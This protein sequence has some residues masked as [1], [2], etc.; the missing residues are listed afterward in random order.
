MRFGK[1]VLGV[2]AGLALCVVLGGCGGLSRSQLAAPLD[3]R[4]VSAQVRATAP[5]PPELRLTGAAQPAPEI[6]VVPLPLPPYE[7]RRPA[8]PPMPPAT[9]PTPPPANPIQ[10]P[11]NP[12][13]PPAAN[14]LENI[15]RLQA[16]AAE[17]VGT[18]DSYIVRLTRREVVNGEQKPE[19]I[20]LFKFRNSPWSV[21]FKWLGEQGHGREVVY[22]KGQYE[23][24]LHTRLAA[25]DMP[26]APAGKRMALS[27][28]NVLVR[29]ASR[30]PITEAGLAASV[31]RL[32]RLLAG[33]DRHDPRAGSFTD[34][35]Q[36][37][38][39]EF[40]RP[41]AAIEH[42]IPPGV[43]PELPRGGRR[44]YGFDPD[45]GLPTLIVTRDHTG[46]EVEYYFHDR[47]QFPVH[48]DDSDFNPDLLWA[49]PPRR[50]Q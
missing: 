15:R 30:H 6:P 7:Q 10:P 1:E 13:M 12:M 23:D 50:G 46:R 42:Q 14:G 8:G 9:D 22:V 48:L 35:G 40:G 41:V 47:L 31:D 49:N 38:R 4:G 5:G 43:E 26:L 3:A 25:G 2:G 24:K 28:D 17:R 21:Y 16:R 11:V 33:I 34:L 18:M 32:G 20:M 29:S 45:S 19:E 39:A 44:L 36:I 27:P 37:N